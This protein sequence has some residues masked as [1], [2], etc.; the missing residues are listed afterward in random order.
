MKNR[1]IISAVAGHF[2][3][4]Y[5]GQIPT[6]MY[7]IL[8]LSLGLTYTQVGIAAAVYVAGSGI[9]QPIFGYVGDRLGSRYL[10]AMGIVVHGI[11]IGLLA[12][13]W[14]FP[15]LLLFLALAALGSAMFHP[16]A[17]GLVSRSAARRKGMAMGSFFIGGNAGFALSP[18]VSAVA[19]KAMGLDYALILIAPAVL[20]AAFFLWASRDTDGRAEMP[21]AVAAPDVTESSDSSLIRGVVALV[22]VLLLRGM[23]FGGL[24]VFIPL[25][26]R[27][28]GLSAASSGLALALFLGGVALA[29][30]VGGVLA[31][32]FGKKPVV[33]IGLA[34]TVPFV[35]LVTAQPGSA[36][37]L[38]AT[39]AAGLAIGSSQTPTVM[40][41]QEYMPR[42]IG[43][44]SGLALG[45][46]FGS[47]AAGQALTGVLGDSL[48]LASAM[49]WMAVGPALGVLAALFLPGPLRPGAPARRTA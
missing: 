12:K 31:D 22:L 48:G 26:Y 23:V 45:F 3:L 37:T 40:A 38:A 7:P 1:P 14:S 28:A 41:V 47:N 39:F 11:A 46:T 49:S 19:L 17:A 21:E 24:I 8:L 9:G 18:I 6:M 25:L 16:L 20:V 44:A 27:G 10:L 13:V 2:V 42:L 4:D 43:A 15:S 32:R 35:L 29:T 5:T 36:L 33:V 30:F 34:L